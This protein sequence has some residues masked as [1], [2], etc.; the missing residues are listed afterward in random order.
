MDMVTVLWSQ[1]M[2]IWN[3]IKKTQLTDQHFNEWSMYEDKEKFIE[4][5]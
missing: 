4:Y 3:V 1:N 2:K 5:I